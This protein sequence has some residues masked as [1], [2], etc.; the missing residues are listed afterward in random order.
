[1]KK[2]PLIETLPGFTPVVLPQVYIGH[3]EVIISQFPSGT[4]I[5]VKHEDTTESFHPYVLIVSGDQNK[6][7]TIHLIA[8]GENQIQFLLK[9]GIF[10]TPCTKVFSNLFKRI[11]NGY[12]Y[13]DDN[14]RF[15]LTSPLNK[16]FRLNC[17]FQPELIV[18][19]KRF[20][21]RKLID[22]LFLS[23]Y[24]DKKIPE[25]LCNEIFQLCFPPFLK[26]N[27]KKNPSI[28]FISFF[29]KEDSEVIYQFLNI[30]TDIISILGL[31]TGTK[32]KSKIAKSNTVSSANVVEPN[33]S[34]QKLYFIANVLTAYLSELGISDVKLNFP[35]LQGKFCALKDFS[36]AAKV[37]VQIVE[38]SEISIP[39]F[40]EFKK[41][42]A[43]KN[44]SK[45]VSQLLL[46]MSILSFIDAC[47]TSLQKKQIRD[48]AAEG[49]K[50]SNFQEKI[51]LYQKLEVILTN[52]ANN[53][54]LPPDDDDFLKK[55]L[56]TCYLNLSITY[57]RKHLDQPTSNF[58][59]LKA[60]LKYNQLAINTFDSVIDKRAAQNHINKAKQ[61]REVLTQLVHAVYSDGVLYK[62][63]AQPQLALSKFNTAKE[64]LLSGNLEHSDLLKKIDD[65]IREIETAPSNMVFL[66]D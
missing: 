34:M 51:N 27:H 9:I 1:M 60:A 57:K 65:Q 55:Q 63:A 32:F 66:L 33:I 40:S 15:I 44:I 64:L 52:I 23:K 53:K 36:I 37:F 42:L 25:D 7:K 41:N 3:L 4:Y 10:L 38:S 29:D 39:P 24:K 19:Y 26:K 22:Q 46:L 56:A 48:L 31:P 61:E 13:N 16:Y 8:E 6:A 20:I 54:N 12:E 59:A 35:P 49:H 11:S 30:S 28:Q 21:V 5:L 62:G 47:F 58:N 45:E 43:D 18:Q 2:K 14:Q 17:D 50:A